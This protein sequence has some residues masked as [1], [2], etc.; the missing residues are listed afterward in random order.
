MAKITDLP[1]GWSL[2]H[3][4]DSFEIGAV[5]MLYHR[6]H[7]RFISYDDMRRAAR[8]PEG[9]ELFVGVKYWLDEYDK[10]MG[11]AAQSQG[12]WKAADKAKM[13]LEDGLRECGR[14]DD[15]LLVEQG[16]EPDAPLDDSIDESL[17]YD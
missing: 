3:E 9:R 1:H 17:I 8:M 15:S 5:P 7:G 16:M 12:S 14:W 4:Y 6:K 11:G 2:H 10:R 13:A